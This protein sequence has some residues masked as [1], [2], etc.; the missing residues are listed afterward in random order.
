[1]CSIHQPTTFAVQLRSAQS[2]SRQGQ[3]LA[4]IA[5]FVRLTDRETCRI[6]AS[7]DRRP[8]QDRHSSGCGCC[9][10]C[11]TTWPESP[12]PS[13]RSQGAGPALACPGCRKNTRSETAVFLC[14]WQ[15][16][17]PPTKQCASPGHCRIF[18]GGQR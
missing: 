5:G 9:H 11:R 8:C 6:P 12:L 16:A 4:T 7:P 15:H 17:S 1:K 14:P 3:R 18:G 10:S 2:T 13:V